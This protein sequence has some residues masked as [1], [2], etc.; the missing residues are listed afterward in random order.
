M[1]YSTRNRFKGNEAAWRAHLVHWGDDATLPDNSTLRVIFKSDD[2]YT[3]N[4]R[5]QNLHDEEYSIAVPKEKFPDTL[6]A[7]TPKPII[8]I[9][10]QAYYVVSVSE[11]RTNWVVCALK[12]Q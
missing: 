9:R 5:G 10:G 6:R 4:D 11:S 12:A 8:H 3:V 2:S 1:V 7:E